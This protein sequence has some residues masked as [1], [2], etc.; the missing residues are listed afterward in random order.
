[1]HGRLPMPTS[2]ALASFPM[3]KD[4]ST[5]VLYIRCCTAAPKKKKK[6]H[7]LPQNAEQTSKCSKHISIELKESLQI[8]FSNFKN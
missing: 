8:K 5:K 3:H 6:R 4:Y 7:N 2:H 1:M